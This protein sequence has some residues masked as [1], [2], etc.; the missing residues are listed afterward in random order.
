VNMTNIDIIR[1]YSKGFWGYRIWK[2]SKI[3]NWFTYWWF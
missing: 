3:Y 1:P 2:I